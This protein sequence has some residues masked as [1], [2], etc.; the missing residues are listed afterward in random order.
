MWRKKYLSSINDSKSLHTKLTAVDESCKFL[1]FGESCLTQEHVW[2]I[3]LKNNGFVSLNDGKSNRRKKIVEISNSYD[4]NII[5]ILK[6]PKID[7]KKDLGERYIRDIEG[8]NCFYS[9]DKRSNRDKVFAKK[10]QDYIKRRKKRGF[11]IF[12]DIGYRDHMSVSF[13]LIE[14]LVD[15]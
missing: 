6:V 13:M 5:W 2:I 4:S 7:A 10:K 14:I 9:S 8:S 11:W 12:R 1:V 3:N 15:H